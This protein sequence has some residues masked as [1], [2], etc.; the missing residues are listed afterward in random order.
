VEEAE[1][2]LDRGR[3]GVVG[4]C[5]HVAAGH[6]LPGD[7]VGDREIDDAVRRADLLRVLRLAHGA[8]EA[9]EDV[10]AGRERIGERLADAGHEQLVRDQ[11]PAVDLHGHGPAEPGVEAGLFPQQLTG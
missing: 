9:V 4:A 8:R 10:A 2:P 1:P 11:V 5:P 6:P 3:I 7:V